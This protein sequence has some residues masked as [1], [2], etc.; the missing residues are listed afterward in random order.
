[1]EIGDTFLLDDRSIDPHLWV[2]ISDPA[3]DRERVVIVNL[4]SHDDLSKDSSCLLQVGDH[5][6]VSHET[7]VRYKDARIVAEL[8]LD[9]LVKRKRLEP[10]EPVSDELLT[11]ILEGAERTEFLPLKCREILR[12]QG[13]IQ[14]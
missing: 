1:M 11:K 14:V 7:C 6:W 10:R 5:P 8:Q 9:A 4:T 12:L 3:A 13:L 2:V